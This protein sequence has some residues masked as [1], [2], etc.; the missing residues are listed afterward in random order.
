MAK[1]VT[2]PNSTASDGKF[3]DTAR[4]IEVE[5]IPPDERDRE[6]PRRIPVDYG[7]EKP[8][9]GLSKVIAFLLDD[10]FRIPGTN[11][12]FGL[13]PL[14]GLLP[15]LGDIA[16]G[17]AASLILITA[18]GQGVPRVIQLKMCL[19]VLLNAVIGAIPGVGDAFSFWF[20]SN[21]RNHALLLKHMGKKGEI[22]RGDWIF[23]GALLGIIALV[24]FLVLFLVAAVLS[25]SASF[26]FG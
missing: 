17:T 11:V 23:V 8:G 3:R 7:R 16:S 12:R 10:L 26:W 21:A 18:V 5:V 24:V 9:T 25:T 19:N 6:Q 22:S 1:A 15:G 14:V 4:E 20:K 2:I 13:D